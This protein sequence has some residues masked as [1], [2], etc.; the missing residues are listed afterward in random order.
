LG[1]SY[2]RQRRTPTLRPRTLH[3]MRYV[4]L[5][6]AAVFLIFDLLPRIFA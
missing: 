1:F 3:G 6:I 4:L 5:G 2:R